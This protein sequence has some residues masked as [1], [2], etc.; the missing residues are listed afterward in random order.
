MGPKPKPPEDRFWP[1][2][3]VTGFCWNWTGFR[4]A[5]GHGQF[6]ATPT[7][8][9]GAHRWAYEF[10]VGP[11]PDG[12]FLDHLCRN[13]GCVNPDHLEPVTNA[14][15]VMRGFGPTANHARKTHCPRGHELPP[16]VAGQ[17][18]TC[19]ECERARDKA[20]YAAGT[21]GHRHHLR[22]ADA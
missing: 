14:E 15:N 17:K 20:R 13:T 12:M 11:I 4:G 1:K 7:T 9:T 2:V 16:K 10:L 22:S 19:S 3:E 5:H 18:R 21:H 8:S 6:K